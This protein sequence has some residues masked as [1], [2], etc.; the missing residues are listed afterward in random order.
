MFKFFRRLVMRG[1]WAVQKPQSSAPHAA[2]TGP[3]TDFDI[4]AGRHG[5]VPKYLSGYKEAKARLKL[6][7]TI[8][9]SLR[10]RKP[11]PVEQSAVGLQCDADFA[12]PP[13]AL[14][15]PK[16]ASELLV[17]D[18]G[19]PPDH[20]PYG[21]TPEQLSGCSPVPQAEV[22]RAS[23]A[24]VFGAPYSLSAYDLTG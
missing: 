7:P 13:G 20:Q 17:L 3:A 21:L 9:R 14:V 4:P 16:A 8:T 2:D 24:R 23:S 22:D 15:K 18:N 19:P 12:P 1:E 6:R 11:H 10:H 5:G